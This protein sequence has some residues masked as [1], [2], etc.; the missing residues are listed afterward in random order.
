[1]EQRERYEHDIYTISI[2][3]FGTCRFIIRPESSLKGPSLNTLHFTMAATASDRALNGWHPGEAVVQGIMNLPARVSIAAVVNHLPEQHRIFH[4]TRLF[5]LPVTT[6]D[7]HGR[8]WVSILSS[9]NGKPEFISSPD[10][11]TLRIQ[12]YVWDNDPII[13]NV[14]GGW[15]ASPG[16]N[17]L[18]SAIGI[19]VSTRRRNKFAGR[20]FN[21]A[22]EDRTLTIDL[23]VNQALGLCPK[24]IGLRGLESYLEAEP[25]TIHERHQL[26]DDERLPQDVLD[27]IN[28]ADTAYLGTSYVARPEDEDMFPSHVGTNHRGGRPGFVR[29]RSDGRT[30]VLP[31]YGGNRLMNSMGNIHV[32]PLAS[33]AF[34]SFSTGSVLYVTGDAQNLFGKPAREIMPESNVITTIKTTGYAFVHDALPLRESPSFG[35]TLSP[36]SPPIRYLA[37]ETPPVNRYDDVT[38][39]LLSAKV[40]NDTL[41]TFTFEASR[42]IEIAPSQNVVLDL[43]ELVHIRSQQIIDWDGG[44]VIQNDDCVRTWTVSVLPKAEKPRI[45]SITVRQIKGGSITPI[46]YRVVAKI[47]GERNYNQEINMRSLSITARLRG[48]GGDLPVPDPIPVCDGGRKLLWVAGGIGITPFLSLTQFTSGWATKDVGLWDIV[49]VSSTREP[50][51]ILLLLNDAFSSLKSAEQIRNFSYTLHLFTPSPD[52]VTPEGWPDIVKV[53]VHE[54][55]IAT[56]GSFFSQSG[57]KDREPHICGPLPFV[58]SAMKAMV[59]AG[60]NPEHVKRERFTY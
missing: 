35:L 8:P 2:F 13:H 19:E 53:H 38:L 15:N 36:Y 33:L 6:L 52:V 57:A 31:N 7:K 4:T 55:R 41:A 20:I 24:Y 32:T 29:V 34:P 50:D 1:M 10:A 17:A 21:A 49:M 45:F 23:K 30:L 44:N 9:R 5:F 37:E 43:S 47:S 26:R 56:D 14:V 12:A 48:V 22:L 46:M 40:H 59:N 60:V 25:H 3:Y 54:G 16:K 28:N 58:N 51:A 11:T 18:I 39:N 27:Y 42:P